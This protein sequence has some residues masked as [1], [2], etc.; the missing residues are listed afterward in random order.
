MRIRRFQQIIKRMYIKR[1]MRRG[2]GRNF[3]WFVEEVGEL[4]RAIKSNKEQ[5]MK[6]EFADVFAWLITLANIVG[7]DMED[8]CRKYIY[9]CPSCRK[10]VC[11]CPSR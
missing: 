9:G 6:D 10:F 11:R 7:I 8:A 2:L 3:M 1:D 4:A 5:E